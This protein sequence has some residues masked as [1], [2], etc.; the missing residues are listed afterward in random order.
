MSSFKEFMR[1][2]G[3]YFAL[4]GCVLAAALTSAW[5]IRTMV[6]RMSRND[7][8]LLQQQEESPWQQQ[9]EEPAPELAPEPATRPVEGKKDDVPITDGPN[10]AQQQ[11][12]GGSSLQEPA[13]MQPEPEPSAEQSGAYVSGYGWP[14]QGGVSQGMSGDDLVYNKTLKD[15]RTHNGTD[16]ACQPGA[17]VTAS[18][19]GKVTGLTNSGTF[20]TVVEVTDSEGRVWRYCGLAPQTAVGMDD[21]ITTGQTLGTVGTVEAEQGDGAH[22][23]LEILQDGKYLDP[24]KL[25]A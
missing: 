24:E 5:A 17:E 3:F 19:G 10:A 9:T 25:I 7:S 14:V 8:S 20:G 11:P 22:L 16:I 13:E 4:L 23:H 1:E 6:S 18:M 2:K 12:S 21:T 15:W